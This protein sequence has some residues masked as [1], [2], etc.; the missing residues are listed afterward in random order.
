MLRQHEEHVAQQGG[1]GVAPGQQHVHQL[2][3]DAR[4]VARLLRQALQEQ[5]LLLGLAV[6]PGLLL[7]V[8]RPVPQRL[9][10]ELLHQLVADAVAALGLGVGD[11]LADPADA[12]V[13]RDGVLR[14]VEGAGEVLLDVLGGV[15][16]GAPLLE[17][18]H[19]VAEQE[20]G[21][22]VDGVAEE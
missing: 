22:R 15:H 18:L 6:G 14:V 5:I 10:D 4:A 1:R 19:A 12:R 8:A 11:Q 21:G 3:A 20:L 2:V 9:V 17:A 7:V 13:V 16:G